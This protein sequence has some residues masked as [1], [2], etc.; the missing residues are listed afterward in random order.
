MTAVKNDFNRNKSRLRNSANTK[1]QIVH[2]CV[3]FLGV[4]NGLYSFHQTKAVNSKYKY[5][6]KGFNVAI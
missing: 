6:E 4:K 2:Y 1:N 3:C 5:P